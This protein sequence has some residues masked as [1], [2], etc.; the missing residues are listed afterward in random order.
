MVLMTGRLENVVQ[1]ASGIIICK[2]P[3]EKDVGA[4]FKNNMTNL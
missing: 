3:C 2:S 4:P 1:S